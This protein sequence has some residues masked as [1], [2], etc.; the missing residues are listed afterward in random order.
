MIQGIHSPVQDVI[1][2][3]EGLFK[4]LEELPPSRT[5]DHIIALLLDTVLINCKP[6]RYSP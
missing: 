2:K 5:F 4:A 6:Y 1:L 3:F